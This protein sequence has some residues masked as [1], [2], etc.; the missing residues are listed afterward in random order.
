MAMRA[1]AGTDGVVAIFPIIIWSVRAW[2]DPSHQLHIYDFARWY[3]IDR[4]PSSSPYTM[5]IMHCLSFWSPYQ[6][7][8]LY[9]DMSGCMGPRFAY[10]QLHISHLRYTPIQSSTPLFTHGPCVEINRRTVIVVWSA[11]HMSLPVFH[12]LRSLLKWRPLVNLGLSFNWYLR[13]FVGIAL[14]WCI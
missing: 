7:I 4:Y 2:Y 3:Y 6:S 13:N 10:L 14:K 5:N 9:M 8:R 1:C 12:N 11:V